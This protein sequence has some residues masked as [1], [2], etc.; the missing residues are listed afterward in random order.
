M[1]SGR[2]ITVEIKSVNHRYFE[3]SARFPRAYGFLEEKLKS[4]VQ[5]RVSRGKIE[6][7]VLIVNTDSSDTKIVANEAVA[8]GYVDALRSLCEPLDVQDD[9]RASTISRFPDIFT[10]TREETDEDALW[11]DVQSVL[12]CA[13]NA[14]VEMRKIEGENL[15]NDLL[16]KLCNVEKLVSLVEERSPQRVEEYRN[17]LYLKLCEVLD[18]KSIDDARILTEAAI[19]ADKV[20]VDEETTR[21]KSHI[22]QAREILELNEPIG[23]KLDFLIQE[24]N[25]EANTIGSK[26]Q[27]VEGARIV[28][29][30]KS[31]IEK[32]REQ[33]QNIE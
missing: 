7:S 19:F 29:D 1:R 20:A 21:L 31:E 32:I 28:V 11:L 2:E 5:K 9:I 13:V 15:K 4:Y 12:E 14:F 10:V 24:F 17:R 3:F 33:L 25:R 18:S 30:I 26:S 27:D 22:A 8:K 16:S 6:V 23:R